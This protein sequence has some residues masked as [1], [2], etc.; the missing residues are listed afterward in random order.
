MRVWVPVDVCVLV[1]VWLAVCVIVTVFVAVCV[2]VTVLVCVIVA[3]C[4]P[5]ILAEGVGTTGAS[6]Q[7]PGRA[8]PQL[9]SPIRP[10]FAPS[11]E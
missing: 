6:Q 8:E 1:V 4:V 9:Q 3:V 2:R 5:V 7:P 10:V 11:S